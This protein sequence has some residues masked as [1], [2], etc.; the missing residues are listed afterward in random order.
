MAVAAALPPP[1]LLLLLLGAGAQDLKVEVTP[2]VR[3]RLGGT[4]DLPCRLLP[5]GPDV[6]VSQVTWVRWD[7]NGR[8]YSVAVSHPEHGASFPDPEADGQRLKFLSAGSVGEAAL[9][10]ATLQVRE[11]RAQ[12]QGNYTCEFATFPRGNSKG[13]TWLRVEAAPQNQAWAQEVTQGSVPATVAF[14]VSSAGLPAARLSWS[15]SLT[16]KA[17]VTQEELS[18]GTITVTSQLT[19]LPTRDLHGQT[20]TC[21]VEHETLQEPQILPVTL[22]VRHHPEVTISN[23]DDN[24]FIGRSDATLNCDAQSYPEPTVYNWSTLLGPLPST[25]VVQGSRLVVHTVDS[26]VNTTFVCSATNAVGTGRAEQTI[27]VRE[28]PN[29]AGA[30]ATGGI[31]GGIIASIIAMAVVATAVLICRQQ[32]KE[33]SPEGHSEEDDSLGGPPAY[34]P[35]P[36]KVKLEEPEVPLQLFSLDNCEHSPLKTPYFEPSVSTTEQD[37][38]RYHELPTLEE[39]VGGSGL[40]GPVPQ[41]PGEEEEEDDEDDDYLDKINPI[42]DALAF[43]A[44]E[45]YQKGFVMS[46][47]MYV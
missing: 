22:A 42:Y 35:P 10:D 9:R 16:H 32:R 17:K 12:D 24:W 15:T 46:R 30:G 23:Y 21:K 26:L 11:L 7:R 2:E 45:A 20:V 5:T 18:N 34:K 39:R 33:R 38:P 3:G 31:I 36:P 25:V 13:A 28:N 6:K 14:C 29:P 1:L 4:V 27:L 44:A 43:A 8:S 41:E 47:A 37:A 19:L 40:R